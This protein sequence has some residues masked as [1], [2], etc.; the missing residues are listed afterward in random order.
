MPDRLDM[1]ARRRTQVTQ[2][3]TKPLNVLGFQL[4]VVFSNH[5][6]AGLNPLPCLRN[7]ALQSAHVHLLRDASQLYQDDHT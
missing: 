3:A 2:W 6:I 7:D 4:G 5:N 1:I